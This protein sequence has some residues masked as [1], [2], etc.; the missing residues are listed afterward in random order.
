MLTYT[1]RTSFPSCANARCPLTSLLCGGLSNR[2]GGLGETMNARR[3]IG[4]RNQQQVRYVRMAARSKREKSSSL[5]RLFGVNRRTRDS[6]LR[7]QLG[8]DSLER[9]DDLVAL[10]L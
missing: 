5:V 8:E 4:T 6:L 2:P 3:W 1:D 9:L 7:T 10:H